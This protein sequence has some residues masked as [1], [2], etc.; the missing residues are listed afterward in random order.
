[1]IK[2]P[3]LYFYDSGLAA[4]L[5][6]IQSPE[7]LIHHPYR[8]ALFENFVIIE[9]LKNRYNRGQRSNLYFFRD[10]TGNEVDVVV[11]NGLELLPIEI[12]SGETI[13]D[14]FFQGI[15]YWE[16]LTGQKGGEVIYG[17]NTGQKRSDGLSVRS[18]REV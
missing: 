18:W 1:M 16:K 3:K 13:R 6:Q 12:K 2:S 9:M 14:D 17:G 5:L 11:D 4:S 15:R 8:G 10:S 7:M